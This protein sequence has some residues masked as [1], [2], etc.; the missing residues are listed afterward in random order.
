M[1]WYDTGDAYVGEPGLGG[2]YCER[3]PAKTDR[4][5]YLTSRTN[6]L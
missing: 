2:V 6:E 5:K 1:E 4:G 3:K